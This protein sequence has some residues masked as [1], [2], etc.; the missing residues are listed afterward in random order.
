[1]KSF[2]AFLLPLTLASAP[3][4]SATVEPEDIRDISEQGFYSSEGLITLP[5]LNPDAPQPPEIVPVEAPR[6]P[7]LVKPEIF[8]PD[9]GSLG[10]P[11]G[12]FTLSERLD[13]HRDLMT[14]QLG[15]TVWNVSAAADPKFEVLYL[16]FQN[17]DRLIARRIE[18]LNSLRGEGV[19]VEVEPGVSY[20]F[21]VSVNIFS[22]VRGSTLQ[23]TPAG[24]TQGPSHKMK[25]GAVLDAVKRE[26]FVFKAEDKE[27]WVL[28]GTDMDPQTNGFAKTRSL[29]FINEAGL[30]SKAWPVP[31]SSL[32]EDK[33]LGIALGD[34]R[35]TL[36]KGSDGTLKFFS[37]DSRRLARR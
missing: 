23:V 19:V 17:K 22:P 18:D 16:T 32:A 15:G 6:E 26:S 25:T 31:E 3:S 36:Q 30:S 24:A 37:S 13:S 2:K 14:L 20:R 33:P 12:S 5:I 8:T 1:M 21:K 27:F 9:L 28:F 34:T 11:L 29:L 35:I 7:V 10:A 4:L